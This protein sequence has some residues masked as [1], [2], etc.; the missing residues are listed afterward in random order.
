M[1]TDNNNHIMKL[2]ECRN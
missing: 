2:V 1:K